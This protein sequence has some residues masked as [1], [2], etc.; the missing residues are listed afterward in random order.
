MEEKKDINIVGVR[1]F[2]DAK[3]YFFDATG[4]EYLQNGTKVVANGSRGVEYG[5]VVMLGDEV[6][7]RTKIQEKFEP[8]IRKGT[9]DDFS[10]YLEIRKKEKE[11]FNFCNKNVEELGLDMKLIYSY[12]TF[13]KN[14]LIIYFAADERV[15][16]REL[17][18]ILAA[19]LHT[20]IELHQV[21]VRDR[22]KI[23]NGIGPCG[24]ELCCAKFLQDFTQ[25]STKMAKRQELGLNSG[26][27]SG[28]C[29]KLMCCLK[30]EDDTYQELA[31]NLPEVGTEIT[32]NKEKAKVI[33]R[34]ALKQSYRV[35]FLETNSVEEIFI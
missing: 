13:D 28:C 4:I 35:K 29:G 30:Y 8:L 32:I 22:A 10:A 1:F 9:K 26:K 18:K 6:A 24:R 7:L 23:M 19:K 25:T 3:T 14:K 20:R 16:F 5:T 17:V 12:Y 31:K 11:A 2:Y 33:S 34:S 27:I 21:G 15:D